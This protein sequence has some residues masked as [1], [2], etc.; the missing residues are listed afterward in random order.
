MFRD[1][2]MFAN[3]E[4]NKSMYIVVRQMNGYSLEEFLICWKPVKAVLVQSLKDT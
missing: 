1:V 3:A 4:P 2:N